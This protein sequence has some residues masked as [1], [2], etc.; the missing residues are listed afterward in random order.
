MI[1]TI[2]FGTTVT[3][4]G[5]WSDDGLVALARSVLT[6]THPEVGWAEQDPLRWWTSV[7]IACA[8]SRAQAPGHSAGSMWSP[9]RAPGRPSSP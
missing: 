4:V 1:L 6:T 5:L 2:D 9:A 3:K 7:V 8:E